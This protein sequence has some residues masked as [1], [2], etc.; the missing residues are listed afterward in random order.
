MPHAEMRSLRFDRFTLEPDTRTLTCDGTGVPLRPKSFDLLWHLATHA[1][2]AAAKEELLAAVWPSVVVGD[3]SLVQCIGD[4]R[5]AL[6]DTERRLVQT[7]PRRGYR[8]HADVHPREAPVPESPGIRAADHASQHTDN[9]ASIPA[10]APAPAGRRRW[11]PT[12]WVAL[13]SVLLAAA[14]LF[15]VTPRANRSTATG[16]G[17]SISIAVLP[18]RNLGA[19]ADQAYLAEALTY[20]ITTDL[21][22]IKG[23]VVIAP[24]SASRYRAEEA[25]LGRIARELSVHYVLQGAV[26]RMD[27]RVRVN[28]ALVETDTGRQLWAERFDADRRDI[29]AVQGNVTDRVAQALQV[30]LYGAEAARGQRERPLNPDAY[31]LA[32]RGWTLWN[33]QR[34]ETV[35]AARELLLQSLALDPRSA[36]AWQTLAYTY[37]ADL[38]NRWM[39]LRGHTRGEWMER[40]EEAA[41]RAYAIDADYSQPLCTLMMLRRQFEQSLACRERVIER[42]RND[43]VAWHLAAMTEIY[44]GHPEASFRYER[45]AIRIS[46]RDTR[47][48]GFLATI[49]TAHLH[50]GQYREALTLAEQA[51]GI[52]PQY[53]FGYALVA[54]AAAH[55]GDMAKAQA[56]VARLRSLQPDVTVNA[57]RN[58]QLSDRPEYAA[59]RERLYEGLRKAGLPA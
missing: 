19:D 14:A 58:E 59:Q 1:P 39:P 24:N 42:Y 25:D 4:I 8:L 49:A 38:L 20:D 11:G 28:L 16:T 35:A 31:D 30:E 33:R 54:A 22:R 6:N 7:I 45:E 44:R 12:R 23:S 56:A 43:P 47:M 37:V 10:P 18:L 50:L 53:A 21:S 51:V 46:P 36:F 26:Q 34:P 41:T 13:A 48:H 15:I 3:D 57:Y 17:R 32:M 5:V 40:L 55:L 52:D 2:R 9:V 27:E 29:Q